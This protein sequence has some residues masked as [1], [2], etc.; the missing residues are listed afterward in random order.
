MAKEIQA[1][2]PP[3][4]ETESYTVFLAGSID[5]GRAAPWQKELI[6]ALSDTDITFLNPRRDDWNAQLEAVAENEAFHEQV[7]WELDCLEKADLIAMYFA[8]TS[9]API[10]LLELGLFAQ[11]GKVLVCAPTGYWR[12]GNVDIVSQRYQID[13]VN[14]LKELI[15]EIKERSLK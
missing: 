7:T 3:D 5:N 2:H 4:F 15:T 13:Q 11:T 6:E 10:T 1:P 8:P 9:K 14:S 12:K